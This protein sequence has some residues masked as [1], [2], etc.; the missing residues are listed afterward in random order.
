MVVAG[1]GGGQHPLH[2]VLPSQEG[3]NL[4]HIKERFSHNILHIPPLQ[5]DLD[6]SPLADELLQNY[7][8]NYT[9]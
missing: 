8:I 4:S 3:Y 7:L 2:L 1:G 5:A 6:E 9:Y